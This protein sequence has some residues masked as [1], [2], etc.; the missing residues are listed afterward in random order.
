MTQ[1]PECLRMK[2]IMT[3]STQS[4][5]NNCWG[6]ELVTNFSGFGRGNNRVEFSEL[7]AT[8]C[9]SANHWKPVEAI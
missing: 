9:L 1:I 5:V 6:C 3:A 7:Q 8:L 2:S 4:F